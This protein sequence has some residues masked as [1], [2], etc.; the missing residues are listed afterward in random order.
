LY[1]YL[2]KSLAAGSGQ[3]HHA[4]AAPFYPLG[5]D[6]GKH[7]R[8]G[9][10]AFRFASGASLIVTGSLLAPAHIARR[11]SGRPR[12][13]LRLQHQQ[14]TMAAPRLGSDRKFIELNR[15]R[16]ELPS[17]VSVAAQSQVIRP[18]A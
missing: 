4:K 9:I 11:S 2:G 16:N 12:R 13:H 14:Q 1:G 17:A 5:P 7:G 6:L 10:L 15:L 18:P 8:G 3:N